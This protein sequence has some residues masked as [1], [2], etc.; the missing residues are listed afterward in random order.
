MDK[1]ERRSNAGNLL[2]KVLDEEE[3]DEF[4]ATTYG[5]FQETEEDVDYK[6]EKEVDDE[7]D[8]D[9]SIDENDEPKSDDDADEKRT[10]KSGTKVY[11]DPNR[12][13]KGGAVAGP[14][15]GEKVK[16]ANERKAPKPKPEKPE[17]AEKPEKPDRSERA[18]R[19]FAGDSSIERKS[20]R[21]ST[22]VKS[23]ETLQ[24]IKIRSAL[25]K[26][27]PKKVEDRMPT[28]EEL[29]EEALITEKENLK[30]LEKFEQIELERKKIRPTKKTITGPTI[31]YHSFAV[32]MIEEIPPAEDKSSLLGD[33]NL[34]DIIKHEDE[35]Q[36]VKTEEPDQP[37]ESEEPVTK[38]DVD[39][40][41]P[42]EEVNIEKVPKEEKSQKKREPENMKYYERT[43]LSFENDIKNKAFRSCFPKQNVKKRRQ[44]LC[45]V[46]KRP[47]RYIDPITK[48][49]YRSVDAFRII[50]EAY[51][52][53][54]EARGDR[55]D[56]QIAAWLQWRRADQASTYV[57][58]HIK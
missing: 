54:L 10:R 34:S 1:R 58:I 38:M 39:F 24:R 26:K 37:A 13:K 33:L 31:R 49:P 11:K 57:Q 50:R 27:K 7:V 6:Q 44:L 19:A 22:A 43:L 52:Q 3:E 48:L 55:N 21:Q 32:P 9:F 14:S 30:S 8:S 20:I 23:A 45:A 56:P 25:K 51:Y 15:L 4:Y 28:Q 47:A 18:E 42:D 53:Q 2:A 41:G 40:I 35:G 17:K 5:G 16:K 12:K 46:T 29:L 36:E